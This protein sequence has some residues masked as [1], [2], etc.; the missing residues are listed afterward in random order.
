MYFLQE[1][2]GK[3]NNRRNPM[4]RFA[5][6]ALLLCML[7]SMFQGYNVALAEDVQSY[8]VTLHDIGADDKEVLPENGKAKE[9]SVAAGETVKQALKDQNVTIG[10]DS[11]AAQD[12]I[13]YTKGED[14]T[15]VEYDLDTAVTQDVD[16]YTYTYQL[17]LLLTA[18]DEGAT[19]SAEQAEEAA[20]E[21]TASIPDAQQTETAQDDSADSQE[22]TDSKNEESVDIVTERESQ[23]L[24]LSETE[25][26]YTE[27]EWQDVDTGETLDLAALEKDGLTRNYT[28]QIATQ[29]NSDE[30]SSTNVTCYVAENGE[31]KELKQITLTSS[32]KTKWDGQNRFYLTV[33]QL[34]EVYGGYGFT[35]SSFTGTEKIF[36]HT[37]SNDAGTA[38]ADASPKKIDGTWCV[39]VSCRSQCYIYY[40]PHNKSGY[41][42]YFTSSKAT[43]DETMLKENSWYTVSV[44]DAHHLVY[45]KDEDIPE[46]KKYLYGD[47]IPDITLKTAE[48]IQWTIADAH[49]GK[50][51]D[52]TGTDNGNG[53]VTFSPGT[54]TQ[55]LVF[56]ALKKN[57]Y[58]VAYRA[59][60]HGQLVR[61][62]EF[63]DTRQSI[64][65]DG[66]I[67]GEGT[68]YDNENTDEYTLLGPDSDTLQVAINADSNKKRK[69]FYCFKGW[70]VVQDTDTSDGTETE[71]VIFQVGDKL[72]R[73]QIEKYSVDGTLTLQAVWDAYDSTGRRAISVN[74]FVNMA[75]EI[76]DNE[77][78]GFTSQPQNLFTGSVYA[79]RAHGGEN[80]P[81]STSGDARDAQ[82]TA[83]TNSQNA[84]E[85]DKELRNMVNTPIKGM[86]VD[87]FP[88]D[89]EVLRQ[90]RESGT[91]I[92]IDGN[93]IATEDL[94]TTNFTVRWYVL[95]YEHS[96]GW[97]ID[98]ILVA[99][100]ASAIF[101]KTFVGD[102]GA[103]AK[104][105][106]NYK[107]S[108]EHSSMTT[109]GEDD[110]YTLC[111]DPLGQEKTTGETGYSSYDEATDT[112]T[113]KLTG[114][115]DR[116]YNISEKN[117]L[118]DD[119]SGWHST[120]RYRITNS[121]EATDGWKTY[122]GAVR[123][124]AKASASDAPDTAK[125]MVAF[126]NQ[127]VRAG[128]LTVSKID[129]ET[130]HGL[131]NVAYKITRKDGEE[132]T[133]YRKPGTSEYGTGD[134]AVSGGYTEAVDNNT[135]TTDANG[136]F[137]IQLPAGTYLLEESIPKG[138]MGAKTTEVT[139]DANGNITSA[140][141]TEATGTAP[142]GGW[143]SGVGSAELT[144][145]NASR[146]LISVLAGKSWGDTPENERKPVTVELWCN[147]AK[148]AGDQYTQ[149]LSESNNWQYRWSDLPL[150]ADGEIA[151]YS[152]RESKIGDTMYDPGADSDGY[153]DYFV[154]YDAA[155]Y[156]E[157]DSGAYND[158][159]TWTD[160]DG[161][162]H[163]ADHL[164]LG[165]HNSIVKGAISFA[166]VD[167]TGANLPGAEFGLYSDE[168]CTKQV[169][170]ATS[171]KNGLVEFESQPAGTYYI[172]EISAPKGFELNETVYKV[173][174]RSGKA[175][176]TVN[177]D[178]TNTPV[179][180]VEN[181]S[182]V[183]LTLKKV[184]SS[185]KT[186]TGATFRVYR[187]DAVY[188]TAAV[189]QD[190]GTFDLGKLEAGTYRIEEIEAP[191]GYEKRG[192]TV[193]IVV[194]D[195][196]LEYASTT[197]E[198][199]KKAWYL[200]ESAGSSYML[201]VENQILYDLPTAGGP[202]IYPFALLGTA[203][204]CL[205]IGT[206]FWMKR[207]E[208]TDPT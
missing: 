20:E 146:R 44:Q 180:R 68:H 121:A 161:K 158:A 128:L 52:L 94:T 9:I 36:P 31:W 19:G 129:A 132:L 186:L 41:S 57:S 177:G 187:D 113:W 194:K 184:S 109:N 25:K 174:V 122:Q 179:S 164:R 160:R 38:W 182:C 153:A 50:T 191:N 56:K 35:A 116:A 195:G 100:E 144:I 105:K 147:G 154:T 12:C 171:A 77:G 170:T 59:S 6:V 102:A 24:S 103:I 207:K 156:R 118:L 60:A 97:H 162:E 115:Q 197:S 98:G 110:D 137:Y 201:T 204:M 78:N 29:A 43:L 91:T 37:D 138:Y 11:T 168:A 126:E 151:K 203:L 172:K 142:T 131:K 176:I 53:T 79:T 205:G 101:T 23:P 93:A 117:Y 86:T 123:I 1:K 76:K 84:Y 185:G 45:S 80:I 165:V 200:Q 145:Q 63:S 136:K 139:V 206:I 74:F 90:I 175:T 193:T 178:D 152:L 149:V 7:L 13:W 58:L 51:L 163:Y 167:E 8:T 108:V 133:I 155:Q 124:V 81:F 173:T 92:T 125:Q 54:A 202:G 104:I 64:T 183:T 21:E 106:E 46:Q 48:N 150:F 66:T 33:D 188:M 32:Q 69:L 208:E 40:L 73:A 130:K 42:S 18:Q 95:K 17:K 141:V 169:A 27:Q 166:K 67:Q 5:A 14:D 75:C 143:I 89:E 70:K 157:G 22:T 87:S 192:D 47:K 3:Q 55:G 120:N 189:G 82:V 119:L 72:T 140:N 99:K 114:R 107:I 61:V 199:T 198:D 181:I 26:A 2:K 65:K 15:Q 148:V 16:L 49:T 39:P 28:A 30:A 159:A 62:G 83:S 112:Y 111:L 135:V 71:D 85:V 127:Y 10:T 196:K 134:S 34:E 190:D 96:D 88:T 4:K